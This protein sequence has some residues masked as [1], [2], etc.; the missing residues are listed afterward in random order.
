MP[1]ELEMWLL[2]EYLRN[3][4][5]MSRTKNKQKQKR[6]KRNKKMEWIFYTLFFHK[7]KACKHT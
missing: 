7:R 4:E 6:N 1:A 2:F 3:N 5:L